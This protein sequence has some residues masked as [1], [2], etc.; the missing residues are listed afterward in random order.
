[1]TE[2]RDHTVRP[3]PPL[4]RIRQLHQA[5][6]SEPGVCVFCGQAESDWQLIGECGARN[7]TE[8]E[9][10]VA[11]VLCAVSVRGR[12]GLVDNDLSTEQIAAVNAAIEAEWKRW[13][14][15]AIWAMQLGKGGEPAQKDC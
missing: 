11:R 5:T 2:E 8:Q 6:D 15:T 12:M 1:M 9:K 14:I 4:G 3:K 10:A 7:A 13:I